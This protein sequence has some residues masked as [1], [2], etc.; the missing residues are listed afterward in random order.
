[1][2][3]GPAAQERTSTVSLSRPRLGLDVVDFVSALRWLFLRIWTLPWFPLVAAF[4]ALR[5][6]IDHWR[7]ALGRYDEGL[8]F[9][10]AYLMSIGRVIYRDF[11]INYPPGVLQVIRG[12]M[13]VNAPVIWSARLLM[14]CIL[15]AGA[16]AAGIVVNRVRQRPGV[17]A[18]TAATVM[19]LQ[20]KL[21]LTLLAYP[22]AVFLALVTAL[23]WPAPGAPRVR[24]IASGALLAMTSYFRHDMFVYA[25]ALLIALEGAW[26]YA[27]K[28][29]FF[30]GSARELREI[31]AATAAT[32]VLLWVPVFIQSGFMRTVHDIVLDQAFRVQPGRVLPMPGW[33][34]SSELW[35][36]RT[37]VPSLF[38]ERTRI[39]LVFALAGTPIAAALVLWR[40]IRDPEVSRHTRLFA[41]AAVFALATCPHVLQRTD[42]W[43]CAFGVPLIVAVTLLALPRL[44]TLALVIAVLSWFAEGPTFARMDAV[45]DLWHRRDD[46]RFVTRDRKKIARFAQ[47]KTAV[48]EPI[49]V[50]CL[51]HRRTLVS[52]VDIYFLARR[53]GATRYMQ[54]DPGTVTSE[55]G[56][57]EMIADLERT[58]PRVA[59]LDPQCVWYEPNASQYDGATLLDDYLARH[60]RRR[61]NVGGFTILK[62]N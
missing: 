24:R 54:F 37:T 50:G 55:E 1:M 44:T 4:F 8:L 32:L 26:W 47:R 33:W 18:W 5:A 38:A 25:A 35:M 10:D 46:S 16:I 45:Q 49:F 40:S 15:I 51:S 34:D 29:S 31:V 3:S 19:V 48:G 20:E 7:D 56:Q 30:T 62:R 58:R 12:I 22:I 41:L 2:I 60:Y 52:S 6:Q 21:G 23:S 36:W 43:H 39:C 11:Y 9:T 59:L 28:R 57:K 27:C 14:L 42:Y 61:G 13:A 53:P 17:C